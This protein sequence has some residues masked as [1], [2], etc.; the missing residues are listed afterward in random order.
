MNPGHG[1]R[2]AGIHLA[3]G[4]VRVRAAHE[5]GV[6]HAGNDEIVDE[7]PLADQERPVL[8][9]RNARSDQSGHGRGRQS[10]IALAALATTSL[11]VA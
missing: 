5:R 3:H 6:Q 4:G 7:A 1:E 8:E 10:A 11:G 2:G 9:T